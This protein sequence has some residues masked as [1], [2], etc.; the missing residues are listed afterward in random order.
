MS[1]RVSVPSD[2]SMVLQAPSAA[3]RHRSLGRPLA[4]S[5]IFEVNSA[6]VISLLSLYGHQPCVSQL[7]AVHT[8]VSFA[9]VRLIVCL[10]L[11]KLK[12][13]RQTKPIGWKKNH[14]NDV[15]NARG[16]GPF[17]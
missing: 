9:N 12:F 17:S 7:A 4:P 1:I 6:D 8:L 16:Q 13:D 14:H 15:L 2:L 10:Y 3:G 5:A 11:L